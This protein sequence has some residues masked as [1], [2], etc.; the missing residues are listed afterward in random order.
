[1]QNN[2][3]STNTN[4]AMQKITSIPLVAST[5]QYFETKTPPVLQNG[6]DSFQELV[7]KLNAS[8]QDFIPFL[9]VFVLP[10]ILQF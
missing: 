5:I 3:T 9:I 8:G 2:E 7:Y 4:N 1:M 6:I 10:V